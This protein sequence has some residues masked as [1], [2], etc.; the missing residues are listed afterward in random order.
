MNSTLY[1][2]IAGL[3]IAIQNCDNAS[4][5]EETRAIHAQSHREH[6]AHLVREHMPSGSG[7]DKGTTLDLNQSTEEK[8][9]FFTSFHH[10]NGHGFYTGWTSHKVVVRPSLFYDFHLSITGRDENGIKET[11]HEAFTSALNLVVSETGKPIDG[12]KVATMLG[13]LDAIKAY[14]VDRGEIRLAQAIHDAV[15]IIETVKANAVS[16]L[17]V[18]RV[19]RLD[20]EYAKQAMQSYADMLEKTSPTGFNDECSSIRLVA[21]RLTLN[22]TGEKA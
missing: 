6:L 8:L 20:L 18:L 3:L 17:A 22:V 2:Q 15:T 4:S 5:M 13:S 9:V 7:F 12:A 1:K 21:D 16:N 19:A 11:I 14:M 10:M